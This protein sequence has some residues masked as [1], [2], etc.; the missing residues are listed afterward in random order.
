MLRS[1]FDPGLFGDKQGLMR[2]I[3]KYGI[4]LLGSIGCV[5]IFFRWH[6]PNHEKAASLALHQAESERSAASVYTAMRVPL[7]GTKRDQSVP[8]EQV[9]AR[10][11]SYMDDPKYRA[12]ENDV[13]SHLL[14]G[15]LD[16]LFG[17]LKDS[18][19]AGKWAMVSF[20]ICT[21]A[22]KQGRDT[23]A[24]SAVT[25]A[26]RNRVDSPGSTSLTM[27]RMDRIYSLML[28]GHLKKNVVAAFLISTFTSKENA[29]KVIGGWLSELPAA[30]SDSIEFFVRLV[31]V[32]AACALVNLQDPES[33]KCVEET[34]KRLKGMPKDV[35]NASGELLLFLD[36]GEAMSYRDMV[37]E[38]GMAG[39]RELEH[40]TSGS[41]GP[42]A[43][44][45]EYLSRY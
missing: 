36:C 12:L 16:F 22:T 44:Y 9:T 39:A 27:A 40:K 25:E 24:L 23:E 41:D 19:Y 35:L 14:P 5:L 18:K 28:L 26:V 15:D 45:W 17:C 43:Q 42:T 8:D 6:T 1:G 33:F 29:E 34:Y 31:R 7:P 32:S 21:L 2:T 4:L 13:T 37:R 10:I 38:L 11:A 3:I 30:G 20:A